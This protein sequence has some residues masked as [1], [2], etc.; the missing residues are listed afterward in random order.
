VH[1]TRFAGFAL[2]REVVTAKAAG[3]L[4][5]GR[6][7]AFSLLCCIYTPLKCEGVFGRLV[8]HVLIPI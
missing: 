1:A 8:T 4:F 6:A 7:K 2:E 3:Q 5:L